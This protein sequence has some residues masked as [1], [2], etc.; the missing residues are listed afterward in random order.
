MRSCDCRRGVGVYT[1]AVD[2]IVDVIVVVV[3][4]TII[5]IGVVFRC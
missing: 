1:V 2:V 5:T 3:A 4:V